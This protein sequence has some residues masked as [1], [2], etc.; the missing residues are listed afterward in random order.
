MAL[1]KTQYTQA[2]L[3]KDTLSHYILQVLYK[4]SIPQLFDKVLWQYQR[5]FRGLIGDEL[6]IEYCCVKIVRGARS[7][8][9]WSL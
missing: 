3:C 4:T 7:N 6:D 5:A 2:S 1:S 8:K 9:R